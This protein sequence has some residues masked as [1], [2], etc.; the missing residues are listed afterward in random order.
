MR[1]MQDNFRWMPYDGSLRATRC[2]KTGEEIF[3]SWPVEYD[4]RILSE[5]EYV[6]II[7]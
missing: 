7:A 4:G 2:A 6:K 1:R 5:S 3:T